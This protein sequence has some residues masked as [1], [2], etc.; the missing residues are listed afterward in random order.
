MSIEQIRALLSAEAQAMKDQ[1]IRLLALVG[2]VETYLEAATVPDDESELWMA[3]RRAW[4]ME[5]AAI[6]V[7]LGLPRSV[8]P[9]AE[10]RAAHNADRR[11]G[12]AHDPR[13]S[14]PS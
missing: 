2:L 4:L 8:L 11:N 3:R 7:Y 12:H 14:R 13:S 1:R 6:E 9:K 10:R 5:L